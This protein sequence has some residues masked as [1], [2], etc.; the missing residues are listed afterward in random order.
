MERTIT[1][2]TYHIIVLNLLISGGE[3]KFCTYILE[4]KYGI[5]MD[6]M[7]NRRII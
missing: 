5:K 6:T 1:R 2:N 7:E 3:K 4:P